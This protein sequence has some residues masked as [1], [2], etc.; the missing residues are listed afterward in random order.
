[1]A[2]GGSPTPTSPGGGDP[3][4]L[5]GDGGV[6]SGKGD[7]LLSF[8]L[9]SFWL[10]FFLLV[11]TEIKENRNKGRRWVSVGG[12]HA[13]V[14]PPQE[15]RTGMSPMSPTGAGTEGVTSGARNSPQPSPPPSPPPL[16]APKRSLGA[17]KP[18]PPDGCTYRVPR[19]PPPPKTNPEP[20]FPPTEGEVQLTVCP[21][22]PRLSPAPR[23]PLPLPADPPASPRQLQVSGD[24]DI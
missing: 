21:P 12:P 23:S 15:Q 3:L 6:L 22:P 18:P 4:V 5:G 11:F 13:G 9:V 1:M 17:S 8:G 2:G 19:C 7:T 20:R 14:S 16:S 24:G 10:L